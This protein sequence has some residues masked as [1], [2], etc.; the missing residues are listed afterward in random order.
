MG[1]G[2]VPGGGKVILPGKVKDLIGKVGGNLPGPIGGAGVHNDNLVHEAS[3]TLQTA[4][5][6]I[7]LILYNHTQTDA[8]HSGDSF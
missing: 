3:H 5:Q 1:K 6:H 8:Y 7:F 4:L 2:F